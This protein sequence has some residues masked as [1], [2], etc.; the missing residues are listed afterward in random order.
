M[1]E[2]DFVPETKVDPPVLTLILQ[3]QSVKVG[4]SLVYRPEIKLSAEQPGF[5]VKVNVYPTDA[6]DFAYY[7][8]TLNVFKV[9]ADL[10][11][12]KDVGEYQITVVATL[13]SSDP[14]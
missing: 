10:L 3:D 8:E 13:L 9:S 12:S 11:S 5:E 4:E 6:S 2:S 1:I 7:I 14:T